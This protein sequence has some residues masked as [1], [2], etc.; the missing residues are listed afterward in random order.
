MQQRFRG[1]LIG[2][3]IVATLLAGAGGVAAEIYEWVDDANNRHYANSLDSVPPEMRA[4]ARLVLK[5]ATPPAGAEVST[6]NGGASE[7]GVDQ[8]PAGDS[9][10]SGW[11]LGF[12]A[13]W[14]AGYR[15]GV[16]VQPVCPAQPPP[17]VLES[18]PPVIVN[19]PLDDPTGL[20]Y[21]SPYDGTLTVPFDAG[22]SRGLTLRELQE[23]RGGP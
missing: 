5:E 1:V 3:L 8:P 18:G 10:A 13:G 20:Y 12:R 17:I 16:Q 23:Q 9:Y 15:A 14:E 19:V 7:R 21:R 2:L 22:R 11:D 6:S 4:K